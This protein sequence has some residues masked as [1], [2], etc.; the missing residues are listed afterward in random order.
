M[1]GD[2]SK[3]QW[4]VLTWKDEVLD[5]AVKTE[6]QDLE[7]QLNA[8]A[9]DS[10]Q[11]YRINFRKRMIVGCYMDEVED[12]DGESTELT[13]ENEDGTNF[14]G[15]FSLNLFYAL[16]VIARANERGDSDTEMRITQLVRKLFGTSSR[17]EIE[18]SLEDMREFRR[19]HGACENGPCSTIV[20]ICAAEKKLEAYLAANRSN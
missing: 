11:I 2:K 19:Q 17:L 4:V 6:A 7:D 18:R 12:E 9:A 3:K 16:Y 13:E 1:S 14:Q 10:Y 5:T 20:I 15:E 8:L